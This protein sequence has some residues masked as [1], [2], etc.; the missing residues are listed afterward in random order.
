MTSQEYLSENQS[1]KS[2]LIV[3]IVL[4]IHQLELYNNNRNNA[5][6]WFEN[7]I[8]NIYKVLQIRGLLHILIYINVLEPKVYKLCLPFRN[9][10]Y[11]KVLTNFGVIASYFSRLMSASATDP[12]NMGKC[13]FR[14]RPCDSAAS[15]SPL[16]QV[17]LHI[18]CPQQGCS[19]EGIPAGSRQ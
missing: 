7:Q 9:Y 8:I 12:S 13:D 16:Q 4:A 19:S 1:T 10:G 17:R 14:S 2:V 18:A 6:K 3:N 11:C 5:Y 15:G